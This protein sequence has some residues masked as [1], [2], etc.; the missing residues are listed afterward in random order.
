M[1]RSIPKISTSI[2]TLAHGLVTASLLLASACDE[3]RTSEA[4]ES[5]V[6]RSGTTPSP[7]IV[8]MGLGDGR[9]WVVTA[10]DEIKGWGE[11]YCDSSGCPA[12]AEIDPVAL[13]APA[14]EVHGN[15]ELAVARLGNGAVVTWDAGD[16][17]TSTP[18]PLSF[19]VTEPV[20]QLALGEGFVCARLVGGS[21]RCQALGGSPAQGSIVSPQLA[22]AAIDLAAGHAHACAVLSTGA[23]QCWGNNTSGQLGSWSAS[24]TSTV[25]L[26][27][28]ANRIVAGGEHG[29]A[30]LD[31]QTVQCWGNDDEGQL[32]HA[33]SYPDTVPL[34]QPVVGLAAGA[35]HTC[36]ITSN[37]SLYC[38]GSD[39][40]GQLGEG[41][42]VGGLRRVDLGEH[43]A[44]A[45]FS[46]P[47]AWTTFAVL[48]HGGL[49]GWGSN[50]AGELGYGDELIDGGA[51]W[52][53]GKLPDIVIY[54][55]SDAE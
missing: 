7:A 19:G 4:L 49:R 52:A 46:G 32:G 42:D 15:D 53:V 3:P 26:S 20:A 13:G 38:W 8:G 29:C 39:D 36:A 17:G 50:E 14:L 21:V 30:L 45:V 6:R 12:P 31:T 34:G 18:T 1:S 11:P 48:D 54:D 24:G 41:Q 2:P 44:T 23:V 5:L 22:D 43:R 35:R 37:G 55:G 47:T 16:L 33:G 40:L 28:P 10:D 25:P 27:G 9:S 51:A